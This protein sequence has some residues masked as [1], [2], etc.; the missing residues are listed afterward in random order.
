[1]QYESLSN[2]RL[3]YV[4]PNLQNNKDKPARSFHR[5]PVS[6]LKT[7]FL[8]C[9]KQRMEKKTW[10]S[11][12][13][14][15]LSDFKTL[16]HLYHPWGLDP[17]TASLRGNAPSSP[18]HVKNRPHCPLHTG[19]TFCIFLSWPHHDAKFFY[20]G[21]S[22]ER[23]KG[24]EGRQGRASW[25]TWSTKTCWSLFPHLYKVPGKQRW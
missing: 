12:Y 23:R 2:S 8:M 9:L 18:H 19:S 13:Q 10:Q 20:N 25:V 15:P 22:V 21:S 24:R 17:S 6:V 7:S 14:D 16:H 4:F 3:Y 11:G 5:S 1:M